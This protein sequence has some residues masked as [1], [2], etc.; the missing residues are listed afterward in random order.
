MAHQSVEDRLTQLENRL[1][2]LQETVERSQPAKDWRRTIGVF[3]N[4][5]EMQQ[6]LKDA[7]KLREAD[8]RRARAKKA[9]RRKSG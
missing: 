2:K 6:I 4:D 7:M 3:T 8:R 9:P 1:T 5:L